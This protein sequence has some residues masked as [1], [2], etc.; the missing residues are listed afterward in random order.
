METNIPDVQAELAKAYAAYEAALEENDVT[1]VEAA[2][3][4]SAHTVRF[5]GRENLFGVA[6]IAAYRAA[7][8]STGQKRRLDRTE[9]TTYGRDFGTVATLFHR[10]SQ[11]GKVG[12]QLQTWVRF[13]EGWRIV[14]SHISVIKVQ[15]CA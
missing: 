7:H 3:L 9:V 11:P 1:T 4:A 8:P 12:R 14:A 15:E 2:F 13:P 5:G 10:D 6:E